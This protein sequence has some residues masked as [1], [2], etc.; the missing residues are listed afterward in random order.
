MN[1]RTNNDNDQPLPMNDERVSAYLDGELSPQELESFEMQLREDPAL[2]AAVAELRKVSKS[3]QSLPR[4]SAGDA[5]AE[6]V[7]HRIA[8]SPTP[9]VERK[10]SVAPVANGSRSWRPLVFA[11]LALA[12]AMLFM[13]LSPARRSEHG[14]DVAMAT[15][16]AKIKSEA[17]GE[18]L[19]Q[20]LGDRLDVEMDVSEKQQLVED[21][22]D[23]QPLSTLAESR[24]AESQPAP[25][26][27]KVPRAEHLRR[28]AAEPN[29]DQ[30]ADLKKAVDKVSQ[31][32][33]QFGASARSDAMMQELDLRKS[34]SGTALADVDAPT[35]A[36]DATTSQ[37]LHFLNTQLGQQMSAQ[38]M[39][40]QQQSD[41]RRGA[42]LSAKVAGKVEVVAEQP[43][44][45]Q[46][47]VVAL[48]REMRLDAFFD[49]ARM[50][51]IRLSSLE[52]LDFRTLN[53]QEFDDSAKPGGA[54]GGGAVVGGGANDDGYGGG[55]DPSSPEPQA[56]GFKAPADQDKVTDGYAQVFLLP[57]G[58]NL[59]V[60]ESV[61]RGREAVGK[62]F[63]RNAAAAS[64]ESAS[65]GL[66]TVPQAETAPSYGDE[67]G[68]STTPSAGL[69][70]SELEGLEGKSLDDKKSSRSM[71]QYVLVEAAPEVVTRLVA[72]FAATDDDTGG[73]D[74]ITWYARNEVD[75]Q[76]SLQQGL[77]TES[78]ESD[79]FDGETIVGKSTSDLGVAS[80]PIEAPDS[81]ALPTIEPG[82]TRDAEETAAEQ[83]EVRQYAGSVMAEMSPGQDAAAGQ[84]PT[85]TVRVL[86]YLPSSE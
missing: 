79:F 9:L 76:Y 72:S 47:A 13:F 71:G 73:R 16:G 29:L 31:S 66:A 53:E 2:E 54:V 23:S 51:G 25:P 18:N 44:V 67:G 4:R 27:P 15:A 78:I 63:K 83:E 5:L 70:V 41:L 20:A 3:V 7:M 33:G 60:D 64:K 74:S 77:S 80:Q 69:V 40:R 21:E 82:N 22:P 6:R 30:I 75:Q 12:A 68:T 85:K 38:S 35:V 46:V 26:A 81:V 42:R 11:A 59:E 34:D 65:D 28:E 37:H 36:M 61:L 48:P 50:N 84:F 56:Y 19:E 14:H 55:V 1:D 86:F 10:S 8:E 57:E 45:D 17:A 43:P 32:D 49:T 58:E 52:N 62:K 39:G 24:T